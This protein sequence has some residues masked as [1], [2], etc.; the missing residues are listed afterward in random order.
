M[1]RKK[2]A[3][4]RE[5]LHAFAPAYVEYSEKVLFG[6]LWKRPGLSPRDRSLGT[7]AVLIAAGNFKQ[8]PYHLQFGVDNGL[9]REELVEA[10][11]HICFYAGWP[12]AD[13]A[14]ELARDFF[15][16]K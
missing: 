14:L 4:A 13:T 16:S 2:A 1:N 15:N 10:I 12:K 5:R 6:D 8:L 3:S 11:T 7:I 9:T